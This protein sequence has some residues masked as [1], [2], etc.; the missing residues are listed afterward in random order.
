[1]FMIDSSKFRREFLL[2]YG[3]LVGGGRRAG[4]VRMQPPALLDSAAIRRRTSR[5]L[6]S[7]AGQAT[8]FSR[9]GLAALCGFWTLDMHGFLSGCGHENRM[10]IVR[11]G[12][13]E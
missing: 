5:F 3:F 13:P 11:F 12:C 8:I 7:R 1:M 4:R 10:R 2:R 6:G 9:A